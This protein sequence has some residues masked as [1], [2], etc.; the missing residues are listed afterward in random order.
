MT[1][2]DG[3]I[4]VVPARGG[5]KRIPHKNIRPF[6]G[7]PLLARTIAILQATHAFERIFVSTDDDD[8]AEVALAAGAEV[9]FRR[10][11]DLSDDRVGIA[12]VMA[13]AVREI[14]R[15]GVRCESVCCAYATAV[16]SMPAD[17]QRAATMLTECSADY[18]VTCANFGHPIQRAFR[19][20]DG[21]I[22]MLQPEHRTTRSQDLEPAFHDAGQF[23]FGTRQAWLEHRP[24]FS[25]ASRML[26]LPH[27]RVQDIDTSE[28]WTAAECMFQVLSHHSSTNA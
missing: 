3:I 10:P 17:Y 7:I 13:H 19:A 20:R 1:S 22:E 12:P 23:Y 21:G 25:A 26:V 15:T 11:A 16:L 14:E 18:I 27:H 2:L 8:V 5:S 9:P 6:L 24:I 28:D 4:A